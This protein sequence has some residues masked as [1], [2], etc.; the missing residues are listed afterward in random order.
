MRYLIRVKAG[1]FTLIEMLL[2]MCM[3]Y[4]ISA[5]IYTT[6]ASGVKIWI[7]VNKAAPQADVNIFFE[8]LESDA[9]NSFKFTGIKFMFKDDHFEL[10]TLVASSELKC[11]SVGKAVYAYD[12]GERSLNRAEMDY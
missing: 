3:L 6:F 10:A 9:R 5:A 4:F 11:R 12:G 8:K 1:A 2:V 7:R